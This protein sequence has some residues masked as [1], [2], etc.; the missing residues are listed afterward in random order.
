[1]VPIYGVNLPALRLI[2]LP[3][4]SFGTLCPG[5]GV[6]DDL[7]VKMAEQRLLSAWSTLGSMLVG[8]WQ[9]PW[10]LACIYLYL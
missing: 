9:P 7:P 2:Q 6:L 3:D 1:M 8:H 4:E 10:S 5:F